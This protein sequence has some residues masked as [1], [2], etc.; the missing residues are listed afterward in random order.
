MTNID[1]SISV[2]REQFPILR[3]EMS[4]APL[5]YLDNTATTQK[6]KRVIDRMTHFYTHEYATVH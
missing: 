4:G 1:N 5:V 6:P 2:I 3:Q